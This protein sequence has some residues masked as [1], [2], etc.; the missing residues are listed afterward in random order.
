[1]NPGL[2]AV[3][4]FP[5]MFGTMFGDIGH[6]T[7]LLIFTLFIYFKSKSFPETLTNIKSLLLW[8]SIF[9]IYCGFIYNDFLSIPIPFFSSCYKE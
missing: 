7:A 4:W 1:M 8:M 5:Y 3:V 6:G 9:A 2:F